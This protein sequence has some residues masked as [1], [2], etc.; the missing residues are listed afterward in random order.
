MNRAALSLVLAAGLAQASVA[1]ELDRRIEALPVID[2]IGTAAVPPVHEFP[3]GASRRC[4]VLGRPARAMEPADTPKV[5][6]WVIG[7]EKGLKP[8]AAYVLE[9]DYPDDVPRGIFV[10]NRGADLVRGFATGSATGDARQQYTQPSLESLA[11]PQSGR[12]QTYRTVFVLHERFQRIYAQRDPKAGGRPYGPADGFHV[13]IFQTKRLNDPRS[14]GAAIGTIRLRAVPD[15]GALYARPE[16]PPDD[17]PRRRV[18]YR[19]EMADEVVQAREARDRGVTD[20]VAW[21]VAKAKLCRV[22][23]I[24][25]FAK[26]LLEFGFNQGWESGDPNWVMDAQP[27]MVDAWN[28]LVP[29]VAALGLDLLPYYEYKGAIGLQSA[30]PISLGWQRRATKLYHTAANP[31]Y[32]GVWWTEAHNADL[33]DPD[34]LADA[35]RLLDR[36]IL[37]FKGRARFA[38]A[39]FR[40]RDNHLPMSF[41]D[42]ALGRF[43]DECA[44]DPLARGATRAAIVTSYEGNRRLYDRYVEWWLDRRA[45][46][47]RQLQEDLARGLGD[48]RVR[49]WFTPWTSEPVPML[50]DPASGRSGHPVQITTDDPAWWDAFA[51][52]QPD[53]SWWRWALVPKSY[54]AVVEGNDYGLSL[55]FRELIGPAPGR[56][57]PYHSAPNGDP[58]RYHELPGVILTFPSGRLFTVARPDL[59]DH[60]RARDGLALVRHYPLNEDDHDRTKGPSGVPLDGQLGYLAVDVDR[61]GPYV[62]LLEARA[63]AAAD[64]WYLGALC[65][66]SYSTGFP[67]AVRRF[68]EAFLAVP[69]LPSTV[70]T[71]ATSDPAVVVREVT[72]P[73]HGSYY[74]VVNTAMH[75][76]RGVTVRLASRGAVRDLVAHSSIVAGSGAL[77][78]DLEPGELRSYLAEP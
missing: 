34:T 21:F 19:E 69:A 8:G 6:G 60:F 74:Y 68:N 10:A 38:G 54:D 53:S 27:P 62:R 57:E 46:F 13:L 50:R 29:R 37:S 36:T 44:D 72:T 70:K 76:K 55:A 7:R 49:V 12:W 43:R 63:V 17:L 23:G 61:A 2:E 51:R 35:R 30:K 45:R 42:A 47:F 15:L 11:Y 14:Q 32:T 16:L 66:S 20:P 41:S 22:L 1:G 33:T 26:D 28:R 73:R 52:R 71:G 25:T 5:M 56:E 40:V 65:A 18:F 64:P 31:R 39:W 9:I 67:D 58:E 3:A 4:E 59:L 48:S 24:N 75:P 77:R 78:L